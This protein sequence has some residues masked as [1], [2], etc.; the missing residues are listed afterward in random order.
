V[1]HQPARRG[2]DDVD[3]GL[4]RALLRP[5]LDAA[6]DGDAREVGVIREALDVV[7]DL[8]AQL[9][10]R[11]EDQDAREAALVR[12]SR[13]RLQHAVQDRQHERDRLAGAGVGAAD[14][15]VPPS[16]I[17]MTAL[18]IGV[19]FSKPRTATPSSSDGSRPSV[20][21][22]RARIVVACGRFATACVCGA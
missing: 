13:A 18:W 11:R 7:F 10:R 1:I 6:V 2:D 3:A 16:A 8:H 20:S 17:G 5:H 15:V 21:K 19:V 12:R 4:E 14:D 9:A 22:G